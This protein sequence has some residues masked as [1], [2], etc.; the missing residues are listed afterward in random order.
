MFCELKCQP[1]VK[2][3]N[4]LTIKV[5]FLKVVI[6]FKNY[7]IVSTTIF[8]K[9]RFNIQFKNLNANIK[10]FQLIGDNIYEG[11]AALCASL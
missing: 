5:V 3:D 6:F 9:L 4:F 11:T 2:V 8:L 7:N 10:I 1:I